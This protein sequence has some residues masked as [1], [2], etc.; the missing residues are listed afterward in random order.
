[1]NPAL[2]LVMWVLG[3]QRDV[4]L[5]EYPITGWASPRGERRGQ[6][7]SFPVCPVSFNPFTHDQWALVERR[8]EEEIFHWPNRSAF[9]MTRTELLQKIRDPAG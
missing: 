9:P 4:R 7:R 2:H 3:P 5:M 6:L 1:M 8:D